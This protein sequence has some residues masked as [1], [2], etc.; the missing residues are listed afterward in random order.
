MVSK[1]L[2]KIHKEKVHDAINKLDYAVNNCGKETPRAVKRAMDALEDA[3]NDNVLRAE[4]E[5]SYKKIIS[6][7]VKRF[8][9]GCGCVSNKR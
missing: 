7:Y 2:I 9:S 3:V 6:D 8:E 1:C 5:N 4:E